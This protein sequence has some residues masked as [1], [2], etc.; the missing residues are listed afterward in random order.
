MNKVN[1]YVEGNEKKFIEELI[2]TLVL[3]NNFPFEVFCTNG[4]DKIYGKEY[5]KLLSKNTDLE[6]GNIL[7]FDADNQDTKA[8]KT[9]ILE[10]IAVVN[11][12]L[13]LNIRIDDVFLLPNDV[14]SGCFEILLFE[15]MNQKHRDNIFKCLDKYQ[16]CVKDQKYCP[17]NDKQRD[18]AKVYAYLEALDYNNEEIFK[19]NKTNYLSKEIWDLDSK[20]LQSLK[21]FLMKNL[22]K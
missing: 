11:N 16:D 4:K 7:I 10:K 14:N 20:S 19:P 22:N 15:V 3:V 2:S 1:I 17:T 12:K 18:K 9:E 8:R 5:P 21:T 6:I 13:E